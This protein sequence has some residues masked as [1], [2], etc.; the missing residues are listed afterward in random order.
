MS[1]MSSQ[2]IRIGQR[3]LTTLRSRSKRKGEPISRMAERYIE[4][5]IR[6]DDNPGI[7]FRDGPAGR[8][9]G[10]VAGPDVWEVISALR[11]VPESGAARA[12]ALAERL[13]VSEAKVRTAI[14]YYGEYPD[15]IDSWIDANN[16]EA[17]RLEATLK[18]EAELLA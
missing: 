10:L 14:H 9:A 15:E 5:G 12:A 13:G 4:E 18:Q 8:R 7:C 17:D 2:P 1:Y 6:A 3:T 16:A 11:S